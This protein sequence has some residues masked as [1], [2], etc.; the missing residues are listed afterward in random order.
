[1][2]ARLN[3]RFV[4]SLAVVMAFVAVVLL[5][6]Y[7]QVVLRSSSRIE[8]MGDKLTN[9]ASPTQ[10]D[11]S[12]AI[13]L[14][15]KAYRKN[16]SNASA[17]R[18]MRDTMKRWTP[19]SESEYASKALSDFPGVIAALANLEPLNI[20]TQQVRLDTVFQRTSLFNR[21]APEAW[22]HLE[23]EAAA[24][25]ANFESNPSAPAGWEKFRRYRGIAV[26]Q[27]LLLGAIVT[28]RQIDTGVADLEYV[29]ANDP[30]DWQA[31]R[32]LINVVI[33]QGT[34]S[35][36]RGRIEEAT[37]SLQQA[38][39]LSDTL[40]S[41]DQSNPDALI[42]GALAGLY[43][44][45]TLAGMGKLLDE[46][47][48]AVAQ[49][50]EDFHGTAQS[51]LD[52][53]STLSLKG[54]DSTTLESVIRLE[55]IALKTLTHTKAIL[56]RSAE[57]NQQDSIIIV[58][59]ASLLAR[60]GEAEEAL[61]LF[62]KVLSIPLPPISLEGV[63]LMSAKTNSYVGQIEAQ[64][65]LIVP[66]EKGPERDTAL[67][68]LDAY[69]DQASKNVEQRDLL[70]ISRARVSYVNGDNASAWNLIREYNQKSG[71]TDVRGISLEAEILIADNKPQQAADRLRRAITIEPTNIRYIIVLADILASRLG[72]FEE[73]YTL[74]QQANQMDPSSE[75]VAGRVRDI[76]AL[77]GR[78]TT[79]DPVID[80]INNTYRLTAG[81]GLEPNVDLAISMLREG[82]TEHNSHPRVAIMLADVLVRYRN[83]RDGALQA[84]RQSITAN[85]EDDNLK[86]ALASL[87]ISDPVERQIASIDA[88]S[89]SEPV[90]LA[91]KYNVYLQSEQ[92]AKAAGVLAE[93]STRYPDDH[94]TLETL[95]DKAIQDENYTE[96]ER[97]A[98][99][100][101]TRD[102]DRVGGRFYRAQVARARKDNSGA[103]KTLEEITNKGTNIASH[104]LALS[105]VRSEMGDARGSLAALKEAYAL[106]P[107]DRRVV[108]KYIRQLRLDNRSAQSLTVARNAQTLFSNDPMVIDLWLRLEFEH[109]D[110]PLALR[111]RE[112]IALSRPDD[113]ANNLAL[114]AMY[115]A[116]SQVARANE[117]LDRV[118]PA[119][120]QFEVA[121]L[122]AQASHA[123][124][125]DA[126]AVQEYESL[127]A[128][129]DTNDVDRRIQAHLAYAQFLLSLNKVEEGL[130]VMNRLS[131]LTP[132][133]TDRVS[134]AKATM[135]QGIRQY[136]NVVDL[137][138][139]IVAAKGEL[140]NQ[141]VPLYL[142][143]LTASGRLD[144]AESAFDAVEGAL[145]N[146]I[147][148]G[149]LR[150]EV[151]VRKNELAAARSVADSIVGKHQRDS[152]GYIARARLNMQTPETYPDALT[153]LDQA[154]Q[155]QEDS[156]DAV[157][158]RAAVN[159]QLG[160]MDDLIRDA[161]RASSLDP[162]RRNAY[163]S[164]VSRLL[165]VNRPQ[166]A[167]DFANRAITSWPDDV[168]F[169]VVVAN[170]F[171]S[172]NQ[173]LLAQTFATDAYN[174]ALRLGNQGIAD[175][176]LP[177]IVECSLRMDP[178]D[179]SRAG[180]VVDRTDVPIASSPELLM[181]RARTKLL[182]RQAEQAEADARNALA[183]VRDRPLD[184]LGLIEKYHS[185]FDNE[186]DYVAS[187]N[188]MRLDTLLPAD[189]AQFILA[190]ATSSLDTSAS[191][192]QLDQLSTSANPDVLRN[193][194]T[195]KNRLLVKE[196]RHLDA[197]AV[198][199]QLLV[200][201]ESNPVAQG[202]LHNDI[203]YLL[204]MHGSQSDLD[205]ALDHANKAAAALSVNP[206]VLDTLGVVLYKRGELDASNDVLST[207]F[208][209]ATRG[210]ELT[211]VLAHLGQVRIAQGRSVVQIGKWLTDE[212]ALNPD[213]AERIK[214]EL[215]AI[216]AAGGK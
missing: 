182:R 29:V 136:G 90:K 70:L 168:Q 50:R 26:A 20:E 19:D 112:E 173:W 79:G 23:E 38:V 88:S 49:S 59:A 171:A 151:L 77:L 128:S 92:S 1:M 39:T 214:P 35:A 94:T 44:R 213:L 192:V 142:T 116:D 132:E 146:D 194:L 156:V 53:I 149:L 165:D 37:R 68:Q 208:L 114:A 61:K 164:V 95:F 12:K 11:L 4:V 122:R 107:N 98:A 6:V 71:D 36:D 42:G 14:Y 41:S 187:L 193:V 9:A 74:F 158:L 101:E 27:Q 157:T 124:G 206:S 58:T 131:G 8:A 85:P 215:D 10:E 197:V 211:T 2:A 162:N 191:L 76:G 160:R 154:L 123:N 130:A 75:Y 15:G 16:S 134:Y 110:K 13:R 186:S 82:M 17:L 137:L 40:R 179:T 172:D 203:A 81:I 178:P 33:Q 99:I 181:L 66:M 126:S 108:I 174:L 69:L 96:A 120:A 48:Q 147:S 31:A 30:K 141:A 111:R 202:P 209:Y 80:L 119:S 176:L 148:I 87:E 170:L 52:R 22:N 46:R 21:S 18:K 67:K 167:A 89:E 5:G 166:D 93:L 51:T 195:A 117:V 188:R 102:L 155:L 34:A 65:D 210:R 152:R 135:Y 205:L 7:Y 212:L 163:P 199:K 91:R 47:E 109:G 113:I 144:E 84:V 45:Q 25:L 190:Q 196:N 3:T 185:A 118:D 153:D 180:S 57:E 32:A 175:Q 204:A 60:I 83:D 103:L 143:A 62:G 150:V 177:F 55:S 198:L 28:Q 78:V 106:A 129:I 73:S 161:E 63:A 105:E 169:Q 43:A 72:Q 121:G 201:E 125:D 159:S 145:A 139:P 216:R 133:Q 189:W 100:A 207:A 56:R 138:K 54:V 24:V 200:L 140:Y 184:V 86:A 115:I 64:A 127:L 104:Y 183:L 97:I